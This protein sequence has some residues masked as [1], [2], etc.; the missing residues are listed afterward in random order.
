M[1][2]LQTGQN[3]SASA[4]LK[5]AK[6]LAPELGIKD[7][8]GSNTWA[9]NFKS[10][11]KLNEFS[12]ARPAAMMQGLPVPPVQDADM[13]GP[14]STAITLIPPPHFLTAARQEILAKLD[15]SSRATT[16]P[17]SGSTE[18]L[19]LPGSLQAPVLSLEEAHQAV[20]IQMKL[21]H[22]RRGRYSALVFQFL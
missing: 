22:G 9:E 6:D 14:S 20:M 2:E 17:D 19:G 8:T 10:R 16:V 12:A 15:P 3:I 7:F 4:I 5:R 11:S 13:P 18:P 21:I 1:Q